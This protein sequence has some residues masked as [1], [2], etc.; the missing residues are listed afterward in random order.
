MS[1]KLVPTFT[2]KRMLRGQHNRSPRF[3]SLGAA[4]FPFKYLLSYTHEAEWT[5]F[6]TLYFSENLVAP[7]IEPGIS[8]SVANNSDHLTTEAV[9]Q[10]ILLYGNVPLR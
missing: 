1:A 4:T 2:D 6:Q 9:P 3:S 8:E 10:T 7:G 5:P